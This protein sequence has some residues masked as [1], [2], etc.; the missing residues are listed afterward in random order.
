M[1]N[2]AKSP[3]DSEF[4]GTERFSVC[5]R[6]GAGAFGSVYEVKDRELQAS[7]ALKLL[8]ELTPEAVFRFKREFR[9]LV[10]LRHSNLVRLH[11]LFC[12]DSQ[13]FFT[14]E[15][16]KGQD[17]LQYLRPGDHACNPTS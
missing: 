14:M 5:R 2:R 7:V 1:S 15:L 11:E 6:L 12:E 8:T 13:W 3:N 16:V 10:K 4:R 9:S 17:F